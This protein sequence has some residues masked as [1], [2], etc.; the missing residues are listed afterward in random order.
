MTDRGTSGRSAAQIRPHAL[1]LCGA[2]GKQILIP[3]STVGQ[4]ACAQFVVDRGIDVDRLFTHRC[5]LAQ[6][7]E[8]YRLFDMQ[9]AG[10]GVTDPS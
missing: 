1:A 10:K 5:K 9:T 4:A 6:A 2:E 8:A 7:E 3:F